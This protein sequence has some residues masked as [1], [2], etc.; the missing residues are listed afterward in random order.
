MEKQGHRGERAFD[1]YLVF[2]WHGE[3]CCC[4]LFEWISI[5]VFHR[6]CKEKAPSVCGNGQ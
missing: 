4:F 5:A 2:S 6:G 1:F 3:V